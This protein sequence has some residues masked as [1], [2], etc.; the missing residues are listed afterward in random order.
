MGGSSSGYPVYKQSVEIQPAGAQDVQSGFRGAAAGIQQFTNAV[1]KGLKQNEDARLDAQATD[2]SLDLRK[3]IFNVTNDVLNPKNFNAG[4]LDTFD[5]RAAGVINGYMQSVDPRIRH[6]VQ[7]AAE[8]YAFSQRASVAEHVR[9]LDQSLMQFQYEKDMDDLR[10]DG[11]N[12]AYKAGMGTGPDAEIARENAAKFKA[13]GYQ[14]TN[15]ALLHGVIGGKYAETQNHAFGQTLQEETY[16]GGMREALQNGTPQDYIDKFNDANHADMTPDRQTAM[17]LKLEQARSQYEQMHHM[18]LDGFKQEY[19]DELV[20]VQN[21]DTSGVPK[22]IAKGEQWFPNQTEAMRNELGVANVYGKVM[23][24]AKYLNPLQAAELLNK[25]APKDTDDNLALRTQYYNNALN[26][27]ATSQKKFVDD[28]AGYTAS[29]PAIVNAERNFK[30]YGKGDPAQQK[31]ALERMMGASDTPAKGQASISLVPKLA[32]VNAVQQMYGQDPYKQVQIMNS[33]LHEYDP[34]SKV[35]ANGNL[36]PGKYQSI[37]LRDLKRNGL[38][39]G[40]DVFY[41]MTQNPDSQPYIP[42]MAEAMQEGEKNLTDSLTAKGVSLVE[43]HIWKTTLKG[44]VSTELNNYIDSLSGYNGA[45]TDVINN[46]FQPTYL[47]AMK[48]MQKGEDLDDAAEKAAKATINNHYDYTHI[49]GNPV[50]MPKDVHA[51]NVQNSAGYLN[52]QVQSDDLLIPQSFRN[53]N[54]GLPEEELQRLYKMDINVGGYTQTT[55]GT[56]GIMLM[57]KDGIPIRHKDGTSYTALYSDMVNPQSHLTKATSQYVYSTDK[58][59]R[60]ILGGSGLYD[61]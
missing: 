51:F 20:R 50:R 35:D 33:L 10:T 6:K 30:M 24:T 47:L 11:A 55:P 25:Y 38:P 21:G 32:A 3:Q 19:Q 15:T 22:L 40:T 54:A 23:S 49:K 34:T 28:P 36:I 4:S 9:T 17:S 5:K 39:N 26:T 53:R 12:A 43:G 57:D 42:A 60:E 59:V 2:M 1:S 45:T 29:H 14:L 31:I 44:A 58:V 46:T 27:I 13:K 8:Y 52:S 48:L 37:I 18:T 56:D 16:M 41:G 7:N 61:Q